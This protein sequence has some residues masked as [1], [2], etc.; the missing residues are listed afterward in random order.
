[1]ERGE[2]R[3]HRFGLGH[4]DLQPANLRL[5]RVE[6]VA[7]PVEHDDVRPG[8]DERPG[9]LAPEA[10]AAARHDRHAIVQAKHRG[11]VA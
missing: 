5:E 11:Q 2:R 4:V 8:V 3:L 10:A 7:V 6:R 9:D 1:M